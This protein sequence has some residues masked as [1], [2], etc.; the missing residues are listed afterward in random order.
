MNVVTMQIRQA[1]IAADNKR[2]ANK[3]NDQLMAAPDLAQTFEQ[4]YAIERFPKQPLP[5]VNVPKRMTYE[6][7]Y[8]QA[9]IAASELVSPNAHEWEATQERLL[10]ELCIKYDIE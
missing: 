5:P 8:E 1:T 10:D 2:L 6:E 4:P 7:A 9:S 3:R